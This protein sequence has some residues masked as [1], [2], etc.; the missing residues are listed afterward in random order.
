MS[1]QVIPQIT[2]EVGW[3][4][5]DP[6]ELAKVA[7]CATDFGKTT[8]LLYNLYYNSKLEVCR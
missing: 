8:I 4:N 1:G 2:V 7:F 3:I 5:D 6:K